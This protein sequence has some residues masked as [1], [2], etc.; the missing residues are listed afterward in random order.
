MYALVFALALALAGC[1]KDTPTEPA[2]KVNPGS[3]DITSPPGLFPDPGELPVQGLNTLEQP[4]KYDI[5]A[6]VLWGSILKNEKKDM[7]LV[8]ALDGIRVFL[9]GVMEIDGED[10]LYLGIDEKTFAKHDIKNLYKVLKTRFPDVPI[11]IEKSGGIILQT[12]QTGN[13]SADITVDIF[14]DDLSDFSSWSSDGWNR[15]TLSPPTPF[16]TRTR[17]ML[18]PSRDRQAAPPARSPRSRLT[19]QVMIPPTFRSTDGL[20]TV[21]L[22]ATVSPWR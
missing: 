12:L 13:E 6:D 4:D 7:T 18:S 14:S 15:P 21:C 2:P 10:R 19:S 11:H 5:A 22:P 1:S 17:A 9:S 3:D 20:M 16:P 8:R